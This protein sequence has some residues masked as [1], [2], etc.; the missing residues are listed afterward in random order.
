[1]TIVIRRQAIPAVVAAGTLL[2]GLT[3][4]VA[5]AQAGL[6]GQHTGPVQFWAE[7]NDQC[8]VELTM[9]N[10][11]NGAYT[12]DWRID[13]EPLT[14]PDYGT[15]PTSHRKYRGDLNPPQFSATPPKV[16]YR[17][18]YEPLVSSRTVTLT[19]LSDLPNRAADAHTV[20]FRVVLGPDGGHRGDGQWHT[21]TFTGCQSDTTA[22]FET[23]A[24]VTVGQPVDL[25]VRIAPDAATG[26]VQFF[27]GGQPIGEPVPVVDG[28]ATLSHEF[29][30][31]GDHALSATFTPAEPTATSTP[32]APSE[33]GPVTISVEDPSPGTGSLGAGSL[34][35]AS[36]GTGSLG[37]GS[38]TTTSLAWLEFHSAASSED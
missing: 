3:S 27:D 28:V 26:A 7:G 13:E 23:P 10:A 16:G 24:S 31:S 12:M 34:G 18:D 6:P 17:S 9:S 36:L 37:S 30:A 11:T 32:Y 2:I 8:Q 20:D 22:T 35:S 1:M 33:A 21:A 5:N 25:T 19:D 14:G 15:G 29:D 4:P 38:L